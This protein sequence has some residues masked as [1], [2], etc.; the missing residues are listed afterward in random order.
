MEHGNQ[1]SED[2]IFNPD[3]T[4]EQRKQMGTTLRS[5]WEKLTDDDWSRIEGAKSKL[6][7]MLQ[8]RYGYTHEKAQQ[9]VDRCVQELS[10]SNAGG[11]ATRKANGSVAAS[12]APQMKVMGEAGGSRTTAGGHE[13]NTNLSSR[14]EPSTGAMGNAAGFPD[15][16]D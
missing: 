4:L 9:E 11:S 16:D 2:R 3:L 14:A 13:P 12:Q 15:S 7:E 10:P 5:R 8:K 6:L 1:T